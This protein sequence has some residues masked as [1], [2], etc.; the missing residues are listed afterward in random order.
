MDTYLGVSSLSPGFVV[1]LSIK[2]SIRW[3]QGLTMIVYLTLYLSPGHTQILNVIHVIYRS[4]Y[5]LSLEKHLNFFRWSVLYYLGHNSKSIHP[6]LFPDGQSG[7]SPRKSGRHQ[8]GERVLNRCPLPV[9]TTFNLFNQ[10]LLLTIPQCSHAAL[11]RARFI[12]KTWAARSL[13]M[14]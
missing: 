2:G 4:S 10:P 14:R 7:S 3:G 9:P 13:A 11:R 5:I 8:E 6:E 12:V 1:Y